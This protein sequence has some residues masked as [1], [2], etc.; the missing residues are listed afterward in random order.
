M[1]AIL[2]E[3]RH[4]ALRRG[5]GS[6]YE[7]LGT[8]LRNL[9][10]P[11]A[12]K[13]LNMALG[14][15]RKQNGTRA[16]VRCALTLWKL[17][18]F[19]DCEMECRR[20]CA[21]SLDRVAAA[22]GAPRE[23]AGAYF[24]RAPAHFILGEY[25]AAVEAALKYLAAGDELGRRSG[26]LPSLTAAVAVRDMSTGIIAQD[27]DAFDRGLDVLADGFDSWPSFASAWEQDLFRYALSLPICDAEAFI[28][29]KV[30]QDAGS[31]H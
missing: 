30:R 31:V 25:A 19:E 13:W 23:L 4:I 20:V 21:Q 18:E 16:S 3:T 2:E 27:R 11:E 24:H 7:E 15:Y 10:D 12:E 29:W 26:V 8:L 14:E 1:A 28:R 5:W 9:G 17:G 6:G 22:G